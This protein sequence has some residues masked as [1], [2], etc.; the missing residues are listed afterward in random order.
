[1]VRD[2]A[3][4]LNTRHLLCHMLKI[5]CL[6]PTPLLQIASRNVLHLQKLTYYIKRINVHQ[7]YT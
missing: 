4:S 6:H 2:N 5:I 3:S 1:M 7:R